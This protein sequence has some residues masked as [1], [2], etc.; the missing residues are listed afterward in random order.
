MIAH[1]QFPRRPD[2]MNRNPRTY[3]N[4]SSGVSTGAGLSL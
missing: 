1:H 3:R 4:R 2:M